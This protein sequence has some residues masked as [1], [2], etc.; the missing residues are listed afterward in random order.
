MNRT[1]GETHNC[2]GCRFWSEMVAMSHGGGVVQ[3]LC[4]AEKGPYSG[5]YV[6]GRATCE[7][8]KSGHFGA[9]DDPPNYG[10]DVRAAYAEE[11]A[12]MAQP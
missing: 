1:Y 7:L 2:A 6:T 11:E 9:V 4:L 12:G 5:K 8:W 3:A 10:E